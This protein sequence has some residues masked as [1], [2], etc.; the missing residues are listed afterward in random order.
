M[1]VQ[2]NKV[3][4]SRRNNRRAHDALVACK[5]KRMRQ[6]RRTEAPRTMCAPHVATITTPRSSCWLDEIDLGRRRGINRPDR[7]LHDGW[8]GSQSSKRR[9]VSLFRLTP[10]VATKDPATVVAGIAI[11]AAK[12]PEIGFILHGDAAVLGSIAAET[13]KADE[14]CG[15]FRMLRGVVTMDDKPSPRFCVTAKGHIHVVDNRIG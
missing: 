6:L 1:A 10:W 3:S 15:R 7:H 9:T 11:S 4:K 12:N 8:A 5:P 2:Q 13:P 14:S